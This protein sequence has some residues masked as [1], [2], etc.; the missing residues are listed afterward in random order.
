[1][2][3]VSSCFAFRALTRKNEFE[4]VFEFKT[5][6]VFFIYP[7]LRRLKLGNRYKEGVSGFFFRLSRHFKRE[8][9]IF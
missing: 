1:M 4:K 6:Q 3:V 8:K 7:F 9:S 2:V 5:R